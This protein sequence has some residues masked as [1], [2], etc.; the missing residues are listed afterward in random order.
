MDRSNTWKF[1]H[2][3]QRESLIHRIQLDMP[4]YSLVFLFLQLSYPLWIKE[5]LNLFV[6]VWKLQRFRF[7]ASFLLFRRQPP[8]A[9][10]LHLR[11]AA[12]RRLEYRCTYRTPASSPLGAA[13]RRALRLGQPPQLDSTR[14]RLHSST[15]C[16]RL[17]SSPRAASV[18][19]LWSTW[20]DNA[21][22]PYIPVADSAAL[23][24]PFPLA[25]AVT[26]SPWGIFV[27]FILLLS[28]I[29]DV[30][31]VQIRD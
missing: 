14:P 25:G 10:R 17:R 27:D 31:E 9:G 4:I 11:D 26:V 8:D 23:L 2:Y 16:R 24:L 18:S 7:P 28:S 3:H 30:I 15:G 6:F 29:S 21:A 13:A 1:F 22:S 20:T 5:S 12:A 19:R